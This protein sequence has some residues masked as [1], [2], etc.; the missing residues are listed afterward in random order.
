MEALRK[1]LRWEVVPVMADF[2]PKFN[3]EV[4]LWFEQLYA[5]FRWAWV[6]S[7]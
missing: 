3:D 2:D 7:T 1:A 5:P 6:G 4:P